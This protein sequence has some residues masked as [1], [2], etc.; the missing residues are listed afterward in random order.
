MP[1]ESK[2]FLW[3]AISVGV[4][5]L[6]ALAAALFLF[7]P[8][9]SGADAM[10]DLSR[11]AVPKAEDPQDFL[12]AGSQ[13]TTPSDSERSGDIIIVY[14]DKPDLG[15]ST[16]PQSSSTATQ[17]PAAATVTTIRPASAPVTAPAD[18]VKAPSTTIKA[19]STTV[20]APSTTVQAPS[21]TVKAPSTTVKA[22]STT[23]KAPA[24]ITPVT[25]SAA[26]SV[27]IQTGSFQS[28]ASAD[29]LLAAFTARGIAGK[30]T[31]KDIDG[32]SYYQVKAGPY[33]S[34]DEAKKWLPTVRAVPGSSEGAFI[35]N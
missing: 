7:S 30:I 21:T 29:S 31:V 18:T 6:V 9:N 23:V 35:T 22:P 2:K 25:P 13:T 15:S 11:T 17:A 16:I 26:A 28:R 10:L 24:A 14:G 1:A 27:W 3:I 19:P 8:K 34:R 32:K 4:F 20:K 12:A 33:P 5:V